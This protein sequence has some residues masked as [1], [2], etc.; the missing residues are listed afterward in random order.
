MFRSHLRWFY[1][2]PDG[3]LFDGEGDSGGGGDWPA[4]ETPEGVGGG[5]PPAQPSGNEPPANQPPA[6]PANGAPRPGEGQPGNGQPRTAGGRPDLPAY[7]QDAIAQ[8]DRDAAESQRIDKIVAD[9]IT[10]TMRKAFGLDGNAPAADPRTARIREQLLQTMPELKQ[11]LELAGKQKELLGLVETGAQFTETNKVYW[12]GVAARTQAT[13]HDGVATMLL[14]AGKTGKDLDEEAREDIRD[15]FVRWVE[16]DKTGARVQRYET[17]DPALVTEYLKMFGAR[18]LDPVRRTAAVSVA[19]RGAARNRQPMQG[20]GGQPPA[21]QP[22]QVDNRD[23]DAVH[24]RG[25]NV[26]KTLMAPAP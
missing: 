1:Q 7:R 23:E 11:L 6:Q 2:S 3:C 18:Y 17:Q 10:E 15:G 22:P 26:A 13:L 19:E 21:A 25:W 5:T 16:R 20:P 8:R 24:G 4:Y 9:R 14:G 12:Q